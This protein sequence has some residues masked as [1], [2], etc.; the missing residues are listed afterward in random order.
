[1]KKFIGLIF[2]A[3]VG[4][5]SAT[6]LEQLPK[7]V[8]S[9]P[10]TFKVSANNKYAIM[11]AGHNSTCNAKQFLF[12]ELDGLSDPIPDKY[13]AKD[14]LDT[15]QLAYFKGFDVYSV[16]G[17]GTLKS[18]LESIDCVANDKT[19]ILI[20]MSGEADDKGF[21]FNLVQMKN[22]D[23]SDGPRFVPPGLRLNAVDLIASLSVIPGT[24]AIVVS[25]CQSGCF[26]S[27]ARKNQD[28]KG[29]VIASCAIGTA[30][31]DCEDTGNTAL[32]AGFLR[33][34]KDDTNVVTNLAT[35]DITAGAWFENLRR[36]FSD[37]G[38]GGLPLSFD[39]IIY[40]NSDFLF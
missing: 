23:G 22:K 12:D 15:A 3:F 35:V 14:M 2:V 32:Y 4:C 25:G 8:D 37:V 19:E 39:V 9:H 36:K 33:F 27:A 24:K 20:A 17:V 18:L 31:T 5:T 29:V 10:K 13:I 34:Y 28:F 16:Y 30:T 11:M 21:I 1:M 6:R 7:T 26:A 40:S 38:A